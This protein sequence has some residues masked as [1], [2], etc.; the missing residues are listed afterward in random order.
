MLE[1]NLHWFQRRLGYFIVAVI[2]V[3]SNF[4]CTKSKNSL[5]LKTGPNKE[6]LAMK[7][8]RER[9]IKEVRKMKTEYEVARYIDE[10]TT[11]L[12]ESML[13][14]LGGEDGWKQQLAWLQQHGGKI[15]GFFDNGGPLYD[16]KPFSSPYERDTT[17]ATGSQKST[18]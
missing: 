15:V 8:E 18:P 10:E 7:E 4:C 14:E 17:D 13:Q 2:M 12:R 9:Y 3:S 16:R 5:R 1:M 11:W 6:W